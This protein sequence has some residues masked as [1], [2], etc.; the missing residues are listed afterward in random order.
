MCRLTAP[1]LLPPVLMVVIHTGQ[2]P[3][4]GWSDLRLALNYVAEGLPPELGGVW[5][6]ITGLYVRATLPDFNGVPRRLTLPW[7]A[8]F[9]VATNE[10]G[11]CVHAW[12]EDDPE[13][14]RRALRDG[15][16]LA[17]TGTLPDEP[18][19]DGPGLMRAPA[20]GLV[21]EDVGM[22]VVL[23]QPL[24]PADEAGNRPTLTLELRLPLP[25]A[26]EGADG[27]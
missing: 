21:Q 18:G 2:V 7:N 9:A 8:I 22:C 24:G 6:E 5:P 23:L 27:G 19:F 3:S 20:L 1:R 17:E 12:P 10:G 15:H 11:L 4:S 16:Q 25:G 13:I 26:A 14:I